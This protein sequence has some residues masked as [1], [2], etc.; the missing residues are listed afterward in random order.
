MKRYVKTLILLVIAGALFSWYFFYEVKGARQRQEK[1]TA[2]KKIFPFSKEEITLLE[3]TGTETTI[4][5]QKEGKT[6]R[7]TRPQPLEGDGEEIG[8][9]ID[10]LL[11]L[12]QQ[13]SLGQVTDLNEFGF[14]AEKTV[15]LGTSK[16]KKT[17]RFGGE[18]PSGDCYYVL[19][20]GQEVIL[21]SRGSA[22]DIFTKDVQSLREK[23]VLALDTST[24]VSLEVTRPK[25]HL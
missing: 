2:K 1:E 22:G 16:E 6:W 21:V 14:S 23:R 18:N 20:D 3:F 4:S 12:E 13:R 9:L 7:I 19:K 25:S 8:K 17:V 24:I 11:G 5:C 15:T 10:G